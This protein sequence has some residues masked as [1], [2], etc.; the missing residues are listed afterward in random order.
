MPPNLLQIPSFPTRVEQLTRPLPQTPE[1]SFMAGDLEQ[2]DIKPK[3]VYIAGNALFDPSNEEI[4]E[5]ENVNIPIKKFRKYTLTFEGENSSFPPTLI[6]VE[7]KKGYAWGK[8]VGN[9]FKVNVF[10]YQNLAPLAVAL[11]SVLSTGGLLGLGSLFL[12][13]VEDSTGDL[14]LLVIVGFAG[15]YFIIKK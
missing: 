1:T 11:I 12:K 9:E 13:K 15:Y 7:G 14:L 6:E 8:Q 3:E 5:I 4:E 2:T 10:M